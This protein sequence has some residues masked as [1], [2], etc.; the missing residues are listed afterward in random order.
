I[1]YN[2]E[3]PITKWKC[4]ITKYVSCTLISNV[5]SPKIIPVKPPLIKVET[6][7]IENNIPGFIC[8]LPF[9][10]V[11]I[12]LKAFTADGIAI[13]NVVNVNTDPKNGFI[14][15]TNMWCPQTIVDKN[16]IAKSD[17]IMARYPK[18]GLRAFVEITSDEIPI[19]GK[20]TIYT[21]G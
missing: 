13:N 19:A 4:A 16:A 7:P 21:S 2:A 9:H 12:Q 8:K 11:V 10:K 5:E 6:I 3:I 18:I 17:V 14:P 1:P 20:I 15:D